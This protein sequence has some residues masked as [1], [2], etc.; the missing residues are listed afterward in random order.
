MV[1]KLD[2]Y[3]SLWAMELRRPDGF[4]W[5]QD[6]RFEMVAEAG[7]AGMCLDFGEDEIEAH[8][9][10]KP[11]FNATG[12]KCLINAF[13]TSIEGF[14]PILELAKEVDAPQV[15]IIGWMFPLTVEEGIPIAEGWIKL[16]EEFDIPVLFETHRNCLTNDLHYTLQLMEAVSK[17]RLCADLSHYVVDVSLNC[18]FRMSTRLKS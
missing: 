1:Q 18:Q 13:P 8:R 12:L 2:I 4:E 9:L 16:G 11:H 6:E 17:M 7:Y 14:K 5:R 15:N 3:Q 10:L